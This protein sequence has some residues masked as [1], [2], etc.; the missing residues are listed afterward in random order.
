MSTSYL[1]FRKSNKLLFSLQSVTPS[2]TAASTIRTGVTVYTSGTNNSSTNYFRNSRNDDPVLSESSLVLKNSSRKS[3]RCE[4]RTQQGVREVT[5]LFVVLRCLALAD[6]FDCRRLQFARNV[7]IA[8]N[9]ECAAPTT[10]SI[11][12]KV[13]VKSFYFGGGCGIEFLPSTFPAS[14]TR[15][16]QRDDVC[17]F[18]SRRRRRRRL[19]HPERR[20]TMSTCESAKEVYELL[21]GSAHESTLF[22]TNVNVSRHSP[23]HH[24]I[25]CRVIIPDLWSATRDI[26]NLQTSWLMQASVWQSSLSTF[27]RASLNSEIYFYI[28]IPIFYY[29]TVYIFY[30]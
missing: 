14:S 27:A 24:A 26:A 29:F 13:G 15:A 18:S 12:E 3:F 9:V 4:N 30:F 22:P 20:K 16:I 19:Y 6:K 10:R 11:A 28:K 1:Q 25:F 7:G 2:F 8:R 23:A 21:F 5:G 17:R